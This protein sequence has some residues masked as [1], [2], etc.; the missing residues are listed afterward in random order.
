MNILMNIYEHG[1]MGLGRSPIMAT[2]AAAGMPDGAGLLP[3]AARTGRS[4]R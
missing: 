4:S 3:S 1:G 2:A